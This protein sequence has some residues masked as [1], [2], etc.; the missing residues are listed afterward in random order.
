MYEEDFILG[1]LTWR[2][3][4]YV[5]SAATIAVLVF[6]YLPEQIGVAASVAV[7]FVGA[8]LA[9]TINPERFR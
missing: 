4:I 5:G 7:L 6:L 3:F 9:T 8:K 2:Q 1:P